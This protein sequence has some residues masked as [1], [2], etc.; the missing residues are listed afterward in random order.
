MLK[1]VW[2]L[3]KIL[4]ACLCA[5]GIVCAPRFF[6]VFISIWFHFFWKMEM[7]ILFYV[8]SFHC[9]MQQTVLLWN[10]FLPFIQDCRK[11]FCKNYRKYFHIRRWKMGKCTWIQWN[12]T[13]PWKPFSFSLEDFLHNYAL[14]LPL[15][16]SM[17][18]SIR[19]DENYSF[20]MGPFRYLQNLVH[21]TRF[22]HKW[23]SSYV[24]LTTFLGTDT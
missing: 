15:L 24:W 11:Q 16:F 13:L 12:I 19:W 14:K 2:G 10:L 7:K 3:M 9:L 5:W 20:H 17:Q 6:K 4:M 18:A 8:F 22:L 21:I 1:R 23:W